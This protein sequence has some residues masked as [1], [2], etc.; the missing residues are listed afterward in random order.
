MTA[1][2]TVRTP[3]ADPNEVV[4]Y[5]MGSFWFCPPCARAQ[6]T[7]GLEAT[8]RYCLMDVYTYH[9]DQCGKPIT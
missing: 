7:E 5:T 2:E 8:R 9:C 4:A 6:G 1:S 3:G